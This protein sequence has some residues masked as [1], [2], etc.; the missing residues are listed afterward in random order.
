MTN[1]LKEHIGFHYLSKKPIYF[2][3]F[4]IE[5]ILQEVSEK[6]QDKSINHNIFRIHSDDSVICAF[7]NITFI[8]YMIP[9][10]TLSDHS[11]LYI[12]F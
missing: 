8:V 1:K 9:G 3:S 10:K 6:I 2:D 5:Y 12:F 7:Y 4:V 11:S